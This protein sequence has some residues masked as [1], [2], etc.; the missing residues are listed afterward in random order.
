MNLLANH[1]LRQSTPLNPDLERMPVLLKILFAP[2]ALSGMALLTMPSDC[3]LSLHACYA[4][5][6][7]YRAKVRKG[8]P[9]EGV[10]G[11][12]KARSGGF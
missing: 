6:F 11:R 8:G 3:G 9:G 1:A 2:V 7:N 10:E 12:G 4:S 5:G